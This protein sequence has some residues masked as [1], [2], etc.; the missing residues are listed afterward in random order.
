MTKQKGVA[1]ILLRGKKMKSKLFILTIIVT[2]GTILQASPAQEAIASTAWN[3]F[4]NSTVS[5]DSQAISTEVV[6][7]T[8][9][10]HRDIMM[11]FSEN[12]QVH[13]ENSQVSLSFRSDLLTIE[14]EFF[15]HDGSDWIPLNTEYP[16]LGEARIA[17]I[18]QNLRMRTTFDHDPYNMVLSMPEDFI[19]V[20]LGDLGIVFLWLSFYKGTPITLNTVQMQTADI[21]PRIIVRRF[22]VLDFNAP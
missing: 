1:G 17:D 19:A 6:E 13:G 10:H 22:M 2:F 20:D 7:I 16:I 11:F 21:V 14:G 5:F 12:N 8:M 9:W 18:N 15:F 3:G 4:E